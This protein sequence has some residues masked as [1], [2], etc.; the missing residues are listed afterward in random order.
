MLVIALEESS[1][2]GWPCHPE[3][4]KLMV[5]SYLNRLGKKTVFKDNL[6]G[7]DWM[8]A[9]NKDGIIILVTTNQNY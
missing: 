5:Q 6:P 3:E 4:V 2:R 1:R 9:F 7:E 8:I